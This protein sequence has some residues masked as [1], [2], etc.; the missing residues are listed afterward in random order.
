M[1]QDTSRRAFDE[2]HDRLR[3][4]TPAER[5]RTTSALIATARRAAMLGLKQRHPEA[6]EEEL[7]VRF[8]VRLYGREYARRIFREIP[9]DA[10]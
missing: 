6:S 3:A 4:M 7:R 2:Y 1:H 5:A 8:V 10:V 9:D